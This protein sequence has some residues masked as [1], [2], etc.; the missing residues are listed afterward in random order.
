[1]CYLIIFFYFRNHHDYSYSP[2]RCGIINFRFYQQFNEF[3]LP[4]TRHRE[5]FTHVD[6]FHRTQS[7]HLCEIQ[8]TTLYWVCPSLVFTKKIRLF[9]HLYKYRA[10]HFFRQSFAVLH[11]IVER[12]SVRGFAAN[13]PF[14]FT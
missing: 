5:H 6:A 3:L 4:I 9:L 2:L 8:F 7:L 1:M 13:V 10:P 12:S 11:L 14:T